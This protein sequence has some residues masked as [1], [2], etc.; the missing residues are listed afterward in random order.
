MSEEFIQRQ[1]LN[2]TPK[3]GKWDFFNIGSTNIQTLKSYNIIRNV[4]Y[5]PYEKKKVD[6]LIV[7]N[8]AVVAVVE[9]KKPSEFKTQTQQKKAI[10]QELEVANI[11]DAKLYIVT[12]GDNTIWINPLTG[13]R[14]KDE[15]GT[16][17]KYKFDYKDEKLSSVIQ[18]IIDSI[19]NHNDNIKPVKLINPTDLA[20]SIWQDVWSVSGATPES[21]LYTFVEL[22][23]FKYL[24]DLNI[25]TGIHSFDFLYNLYNQKNEDDSVLSYYVK[26][27]RPYIKQIFKAGKDGTTIING[28]VFVSV[29]E[30]TDVRYKTVFHKVLTKFNNYGKLENIDY[31]FKSKLFE[32]F[33]KQSISKKNW[34][35]F[36]TPLCVVRA[37]V[38]MAEKKIKPGITICDPACGVGKFLLEPV[39]H[40]LNLFYETKPSG[41]II[42]KIKLIGFDKGFDKDE[43]KTIILAKANMVIYFSNLLKEN[44]HIITHLSELLNESFE[45]KTNSILGTLAYTAIEEYDLILTNPP[46]VTSGSSNLKD[47]IK[48]DARLKDYYKKD[49]M[50]VEGLFMEWIVRALKPGGTA[51]VIVPDG[52]MNRQNDSTLRE[53]IKD[54][55]YIN[56]IISLPLKTFFTTQKKTYIL[57]ITKKHDEKDNQTTPVFTYLV[58]E[59]GESRDVYRFEI[60]Q[61]DLYDA[62]KMFKSFMGSMDYFIENNNNPR[63][64]IQP[65]TLFDP[66]SHW[67][68][69]RWW[70]NEEKIRLG[71]EEQHDTLTIQELGNS[72]SDMVESLRELSSSMNEI[73][74][75]QDFSYMLKEKCLSDKKLF[76]LSIGKRVVKRDFHKMSGEFPIYS[77]N[78]HE[79]IG[80]H[81]SSNIDDFDYNY[82]IWGIDGNFEF[83]SIPKGTK[84]RYT[85]HCGAIKILDDHIL[86]EYLMIQLEQAKV[87]YGFDRGL[88]S[89]LKNMNVIEIQIPYDK[90][91]YIDVYAQKKIIRQYLL[92]VEL[93]SKLKEY[94][95]I[96]D[97]IKLTF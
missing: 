17:L 32:S 25:L 20:Q 2:N 31:D 72:V 82:V 3:I 1:I 65:I 47:E 38:D 97:N 70:T 24:S 95:D 42:P 10:K 61:N 78:V 48:K 90:D 36:F 60:E 52:I 79:P 87:K 33:L 50:G 94:Q 21:C 19:N 30:E 34:G 39:L 53:F 62:V 13:N 76:D 92:M 85:D 12:D 58:S 26:T 18:K 54:S 28:S 27:I 46:Y 14:I 75:N 8:K 4:D 91:G 69:D 35:Q 59:I 16:I 45:L 86:P 55:C 66:R 56:C 89:S 81:D 7:L 37:I 64:K 49:G 73:D 83:N 15:N 68:I 40:K 44:P 29:N 96:I 6:G 9:Y 57:G 63:C 88:R 84:F 77:A 80:Y 74:E 41:E 23:I 93:K 51:Y 11:L 71:I 22:F 5:S 67:S 43:Q